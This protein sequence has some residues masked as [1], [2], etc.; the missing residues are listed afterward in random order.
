LLIERWK[1]LPTEDINGFLEKLSETCCWSVPEE[2]LLLNWEEIHEM[3]QHG[4]SFGSHSATHRILTRLSVKEIQKEVEGSLSVLRENKVNHTPVFC[5]PNGDYTPEVVSQVKLAG[6]Q[7]AVSTRFGFENSHTQ[8]IF[9][10]KRIGI[11]HDISATLPLFSFHL[12]GMNLKMAK[13]KGRTT[14]SRP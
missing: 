2:R 10:L 11:H 5:Y 9:T 8:D 4:I 6:Y 3:S 1:D 12:A 7:A 13:K 14:R